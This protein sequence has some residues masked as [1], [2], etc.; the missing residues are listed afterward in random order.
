MGRRGKKEREI[1]LWPSNIIKKT[2]TNRDK[3]KGFLKETVRNLT[4]KSSVRLLT[5]ITERSK[6]KPTQRKKFYM[7]QT[8]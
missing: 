2:E 4:D 7:V 6:N 1:A 8:Q 5:C 3:T